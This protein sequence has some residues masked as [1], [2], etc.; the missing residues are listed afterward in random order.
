[1]A[2]GTVTV[3]VR[4]DT[5]PIEDELRRIGECWRTRQEVEA[6]ERFTAAAPWYETGTAAG[7]PVREVRAP[8]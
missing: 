2:P 1:M 4:V 5:E 3:D 7:T 8:R 6:E